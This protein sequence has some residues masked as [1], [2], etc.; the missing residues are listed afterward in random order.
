MSTT[1]KFRPTEAAVIEGH[2]RPSD[3]ESLTSLGAMMRRIRE[4]LAVA[5]FC[6]RLEIAPEQ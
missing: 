1:L 5:E 3:H 6:E 2:M 4:D